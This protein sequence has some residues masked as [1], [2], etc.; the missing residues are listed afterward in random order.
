MSKLYICILFIVSQIECLSFLY[1]PL[2]VI[3]PQIVLVYK[4]VSVN[5]INAILNRGVFY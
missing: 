4:L 2:T 5:K 1:I 3:L